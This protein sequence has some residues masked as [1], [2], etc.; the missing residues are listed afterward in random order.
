MSRLA[1]FIKENKEAVYMLA[2][3]NTTR[4]ENGQIVLLE[5]DEWREE[6]EWDDFFDEL[7]RE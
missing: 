3:R 5:N 4:N 2:E 6:S 1:E 7:R